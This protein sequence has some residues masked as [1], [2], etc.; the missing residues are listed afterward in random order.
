[1]IKNFNKEAL[2]KILTAII[3]GSI[4]LL[5][6]TIFTEDN[7]GRSQ[8][9]SKKNSR[10]SSLS[11]ILSQVEGVGDVDVKVEY[12]KE[13]QVIGVM[14]AAEGGNYPLVKKNI[15]DGVST[16]YNIPKSKVAVLGK[17][18]NEKEEN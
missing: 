8:I 5:T 18:N 4:L 7:D 1:M 3:I 17:I 2:T 9:T 11:S 10:E 16:L 14:V 15:I 6:I 12:D 13:E